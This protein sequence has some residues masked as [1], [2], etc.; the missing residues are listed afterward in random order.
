VEQDGEIAYK[1][2]HGVDSVVNTDPDCDV[3]LTE[4]GYAS[5]S[6]L[7]WNLQMNAE[8]PDVSGFKM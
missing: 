1:Y 2:T 6:K 5:L 4:A 3:L 7:T 8:D